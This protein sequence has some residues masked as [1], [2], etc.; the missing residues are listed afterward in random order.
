MTKNAFKPWRRHGTDD[1]ADWTPGRPITDIAE[2]KVGDIVFID[3]AQHEA[4]NLAKVLRSSTD[5]T[6]AILRMVNPCDTSETRRFASPEGF[7]KWGG[8]AGMTNADGT[9]VLRRAERAKE[10]E[11]FALSTT[12]KRN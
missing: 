9:P 2:L 12:P 3:S 6:P 8:K 5:E 4:L 10:A 7:A 1:F 11:E